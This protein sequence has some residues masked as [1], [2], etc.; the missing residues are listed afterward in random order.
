MLCCVA[1]VERL[2]EHH[3]SADYMFWSLGS[4][5]SFI[6]ILKIELLKPVLGG[7]A[8]AAHRWTWFG[9][10]SRSSGLAK[11]VLQG[12]VKEKEA[13]RRRGGKTISKTSSTRTAENRTR[14]KGIVRMHLW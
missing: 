12:T 8:G 10:V 6:V 2:L 11:T 1:A 9:P 13:D 4:L 3:Q 5:S 7:V 14:R